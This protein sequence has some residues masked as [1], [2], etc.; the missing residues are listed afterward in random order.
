MSSVRSTSASSSALPEIPAPI[1]KYGLKLDAAHFSREFLPAANDE[2]LMTDSLGFLFRN[3][4]GCAYPPHIK[5]SVVPRLRTE[6]QSRHDDV[7]L[8]F[9]GAPI[10]TDV[11]QLAIALVEQRDMSMVDLDF[12]RWIESAVS[13]RGWGY[14]EAMDHG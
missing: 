3:V 9:P 11:A 8:A 10:L 6:W 12:P 4:L 13:R 1:E 7:F 2:P 5:A 14:V